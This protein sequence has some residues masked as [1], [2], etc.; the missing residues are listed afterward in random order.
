MMTFTN[1][2]APMVQNYDLEGASRA[3]RE[4]SSSSTLQTLYGASVVML[5]IYGRYAVF[6]KLRISGIMTDWK[7]W[8]VPS[9]C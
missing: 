6:G 9:A 5:P 7:Y 8:L 1:E 2:R 4:G 3:L